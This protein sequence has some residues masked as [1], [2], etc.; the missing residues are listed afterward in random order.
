VRCRCDAEVRV[1][2]RVRVLVSFAGYSHA[3]I[4]GV[5]VAIIIFVFSLLRGVGMERGQ[6][7]R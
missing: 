4:N 3:S 2:K 7:E 5:V 1:V 6:S